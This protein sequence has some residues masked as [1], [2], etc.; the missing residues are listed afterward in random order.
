MSS[1]NAEGEFEARDIYGNY[2]PVDGIVQ[3]HPLS[4][5]CWIVNSFG[6]EKFCL[7]FILSRV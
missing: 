1:I 6:A 4:C 3:V 5:L 7:F 2:K